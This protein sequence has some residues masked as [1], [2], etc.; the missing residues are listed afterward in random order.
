MLKLTGELFKAAPEAELCDY[1]EKAL[2]KHILGSIDSLDGTTIYFLGLKPGLFKVYATPMESFWCCNG[3]GMEN[4]AKYGDSIYFHDE[5]NLWVNLYIASELDWKKLGLKVR[6]ET[7]YPEEEGSRFLF[8]LEK[9]VEMTVNLRIPGWATNGGTVSINGTLLQAELRPGSYLPVKRLWNDGD[10][11]AISLPMSLRTYHAEDD[12][13]TVAFYYGPVLLAGE[14]G[15]ESYPETDHARKQLDFSKLPVPQ[16]PVLVGVDPD[17]PGEWMKP[18][19][20]KPLTFL[21][22]NAVRPKDLLLSPFYAIHHQRYAVYLKCMTS[23]EWN[24]S[25]KVVPANF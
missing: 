25:N 22:T 6:Q 18:V 23:E 24:Q 7:A 8:H 20:G 11:L 12:P 19:E 4:H 13:K 9:P 3:S 17:H 2:Y 14:M 5:G 21:T 1:Y 10:T 16:A 15:R